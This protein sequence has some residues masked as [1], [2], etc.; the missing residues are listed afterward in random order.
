MANKPNT[1]QNQIF[2]GTQFFLQ[3]GNITTFIAFAGQGFKQG[4]ML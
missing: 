4:P 3:K 2:N 1:K